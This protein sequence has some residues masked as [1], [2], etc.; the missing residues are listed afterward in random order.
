MKRVMILSVAAMALSLAMPRVA[1][2]TTV[3]N[4]IAAIQDK[5]IKYQE[6]TV[7][8]I[9]E[10]VTKTLSRD[11]PGY[12]TDNAFK[13][14]DGSYKLNVS[15]GNN[16]LVLFFDEQGKLIKTEKPTSQKSMK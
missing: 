10:A 7:V 1:H 13:G 8:E 6:I 14:D 12:K 5:E 9:P 4:V 16:K 15:L 3:Q 2:A 11:Y